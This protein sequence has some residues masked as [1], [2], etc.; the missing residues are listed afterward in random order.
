MA[1]VRHPFKNTRAPDVGRK[2]WTTFRVRHPFKNTRAPDL[3]S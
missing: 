1:K 3:A 2:A